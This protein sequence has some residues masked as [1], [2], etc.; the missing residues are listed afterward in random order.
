M[1]PSR[2]TQRLGDFVMMK[3]LFLENMDAALHELLSQFAASAAEQRTANNNA[4]DIDVGRQL[5]D[6]R[7]QRDIIVARAG[8]RPFAAASEQARKFERTVRCAQSFEI[9]LPKR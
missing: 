1:V 2:D 5:F 3:R 9:N 8:S 4:G 7:E 6:R